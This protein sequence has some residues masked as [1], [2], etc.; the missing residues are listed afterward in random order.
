MRRGSRVI[1]IAA[2]TAATCAAGVSR[3]QAAIIDVTG[4]ITTSQTWT[5]NNEYILTQVIYV[6]SGATLTVEP[7]TVVRGEPE[8]S[9][10]AHDPGTLV[11]TR[12]S[13]LF[14]LGTASAPIVFTDLLDDNV[15]GGTGTFPY[16][17]LDNAL[18]L[19]GQWGGVILLGRGYVANNTSLGPDAT[20]EVQIEGLTATGSLGFYGN[21]GND[22]DDSG[23][24]T[25]VSV[26]YGGFNLSANNEINGLT[27]G[28][29]GRSTDIDHIE[30]FQNKD[31]GVEMF[32][33]AVNLKHVMAVNGGDDGIDYDE[34]WRGKAQF[35][36]V[37]QGTPGADK[38]DKGGEHDGGN[39]PDGSQ[40]MSI[41][42]FYNATYV[43]LGQKT[44]TDKLKNTALIFRD[45]AGGRYYNSFFADFGG[46][47]ICIE[48]GNTGGS[49]TAANSS[50]ERSIT[51]YVTDGVY[52]FPPASSFQLELQDSTWWC[53]GNGGAVPTGDATAS[54]CDSGKVHHDNGL[55]SV[56][57]LDNAYLGCATALPIR[58]LQRTPVG[59]STVPDPITLIDPRPTG[60]G[61]LV[62]TNRTP[63]N[64]GFFS[65]A[66]YRGA[67][68]PG[69]NW[70]AG[71]SSM[72]RLG[73]YSVCGAG[74]GSSVPEEVRNVTLGGP[75]R[76][77][78][79]RI[80]W[81]PPAGTGSGA[82]IFYDVLRSG[83]SGNFGAATCLESNDGSDTSVTDTAVPALG[84]AFNYLI[85]AG[86]T[87][88][89][90][91]LGE[92]SS[93]VERTGVTCP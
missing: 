82:G 37:M 79:T 86:A 33:G 43:G 41:P 76:N 53:A 20:R 24:M 31:D 40:P 9:P 66:P 46:A 81:S 67:F 80:D 51:A 29:V 21:G 60:G 77:D 39:G 15:R 16:D 13:K 48:G 47:P 12:G 68:S 2:L 34:G 8:S 70:A 71:W 14:A 22:D 72:A 42:T 50:G 36:F 7:G 25:Y 63:P 93:G 55:F 3:V 28:A 27:L 56:A 57:A 58:A 65:P 64:D 59:S 26:R 44:Y 69:S 11:I 73:Y 87:C 62:S 45:N 52:Y 78:P 35:I 18:S 74:A 54:G 23:T 38:S 10:G 6:T 89:E 88:G 84:Q 91:S 1:A 5:S 61:P 30:V 90:G 4:N 49:S 19:T 83:S 75:F 32:G 17:T 85:R 92:R